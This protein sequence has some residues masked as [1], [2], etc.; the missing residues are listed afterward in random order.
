MI[1]QVALD[2]AA[3]ALFREGYRGSVDDDPTFPDR[4][5]SQM[6]TEQRAMYYRWA[7]SALAA[8]ER[9]E[10]ASDGGTVV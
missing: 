10:A 4:V 9:A 1:T 8:A 5:W 2:A 3:V 6:S 7:D